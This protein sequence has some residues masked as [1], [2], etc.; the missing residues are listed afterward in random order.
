MATTVFVKFEFS[1]TFTL[2]IFRKCGK[3][4]IVHD[5]KKCGKF[6]FKIKIKKPGK[7]SSF[8]NSVYSEYQ[9]F[10]QFLCFS[11]LSESKEFLD[12]LS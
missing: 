7:I 2:L 9:H 3:I 4:Q 8:A 12:T 6:K 5:F 10:L 1:R 11:Y